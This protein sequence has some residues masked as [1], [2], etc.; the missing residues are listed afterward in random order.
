MNNKGN[1][2]KA[3]GRYKNW[4]GTRRKLLLCTAQISEKEWE[5]TC[6]CGNKITVSGTRLYHVKTCGLKCKVLNKERGAAHRKPQNRTI[7]EAYF[8][9]KSNQ[10]VRGKGF[11]KREDWESL[12]FQPCAYCGEI[13]TRNY[14]KYPAYQKKMRNFLTP[15]IIAEYNVQMNG[16]D[17]VDS[18]KGYALDNCVS[19]C[20]HCNIIKWDYSIEEFFN[21]IKKIYEKNIKNRNI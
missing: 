10:S 18:L 21:K 6:D 17:R 19:C 14:A 2:G 11:L 16:V 9:H 5:W 8:A 1:F 12:V 13:D 15:E 3:N 20:S 7:T 4:L